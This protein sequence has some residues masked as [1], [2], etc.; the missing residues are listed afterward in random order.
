[1]KPR[2]RVKKTQILK[3]SSGLGDLSATRREKVPKRR[4]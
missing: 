3:R 2:T 1:M 4:K